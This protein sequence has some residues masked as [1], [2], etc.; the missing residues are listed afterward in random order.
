MKY[1]IGV[2]LTLLVLA[3]AALAVLYGGRYDIAASS[4]HTALEQWL[5]STT[6][7][8]A[9]IRGAERSV[10][11]RPRDLTSAVR[12]ARGARS[13]DDHCHRCHGA[14]GAEPDEMGKGLTPQAPDLARAAERWTPEQLFWIVSHGIKMTGM[15]AWGRSHQPDGIWDHVAFVERL[16][17]KH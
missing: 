10:P 12:V 9:V 3:V 7:R 8:N 16:P 14:P 1:A 15:P 11:E 17:H 5:F 13:F 6:M 4:P 2:A